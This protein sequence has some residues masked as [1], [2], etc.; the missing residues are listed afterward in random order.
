MTIVLRDMKKFLLLLF[1]SNIYLNNWAQDTLA[2]ITYDTLGSYPYFHY[3]YWPGRENYHDSLQC[4]RSEAMFFGDPDHMWF[5]PHNA[6]HEYAFSQHADDTIYVVGIAYFFP[7]SG[8][9]QFRIY[10][11]LSSKAV[12]VAETEEYMLEGLASFPSDTSMHYFE[13][14]SYLLHGWYQWEKFAYFQTPVTL[15]GTFYISSTVHW[16]TDTSRRSPQIIYQLYE[17]HPEP[18]LFKKHH[19]CEL[20]DTGWTVGDSSRAIPMVFPIIV[21]QCRNDINALT[22]VFDSGSQVLT[23]TWDTTDLRG[24]PRGMTAPAVDLWLGSMGSE[25]DTNGMVRTLLPP[26]RSDT[27][28]PGSYV[29]YVRK[30][31]N[32]QYNITADWQHITSFTVPS[33]EEEI[34]PL[35]VTSNNIIIS[36]NPVNDNMVVETDVSHGQLTLHDATGREVERWSV[37][38]GRTTV[39]VSHL[40]SGSYLLVFTSSHGMTTRRVIKVTHY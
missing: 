40:P 25:P 13:M 17:D 10:D 30:V 37:R 19:F 24:I 21:P 14:P 22:A 34:D 18:Y 4:F 6:N 29:L 39:D 27:L 11:T 26:W 1:F 12:A 8:R 15:V 5:T 28:T 16:L 36:P 23:V 33:Q 2:P 7:N 9:H 20:T 35:H 38:A 31:C 3:S 32:P